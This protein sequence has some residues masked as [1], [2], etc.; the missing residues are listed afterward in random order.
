[1]NIKKIYLVRHGQTDMNLKGI[2]QGSGVDSSLNVTGK[3]QA[4][5]FYEKYGNLPFDKIYISALQ[6]TKESVEKFIDKGLPTEVLPE[7][8][9]ISWGI[10]EGKVVDEEGSAYYKA[11]LKA[12]KMGQ[13]DVR[14]EGGE[15]PDEMAIRLKFALDYIMEKNEE[16]EILICMHGRAMRAMLCLMLNF[17]LKAMDIFEH[18]NLCL[19]E[20]HHT[21]SVFTIA[22]FMDLSHMES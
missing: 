18:E 1:L 3:F 11:M 4:K 9:E 22:K 8:N 19:Y 10:R 5:K 16:H 14:I 20:L 2:V 15:S 7:L 17:P 12:W 13:T 6:R 21:G